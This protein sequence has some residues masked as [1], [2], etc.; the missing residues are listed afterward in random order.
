MKLSEIHTLLSKTRKERNLA[1]RDIASSLNVEQATISLYENGKRGIPLDLLDA[2]L[3][4]LEI[5]IKATPQSL[6]P[7]NRT[8]DIEHDLHTFRELK[9]KRNRLIAEIRAITAEKLL[10]IPKF[11]QTEP[12]SGES[13]FWPY[14]FP[15]TE[16]VGLVETRYDHPEQKHLAV[17]YTNEEVNIY[18]FVPVYEAENEQM[19]TGWSDIKRIYFSEDEFLNLGGEWE[20]DQMEKHK[21]TIL[22]KHANHPDGVEII[23]PEGFPIRALLDMVENYTF[24]SK[25]IK[26]LYLDWQLIKMKH[27]LDGIRKDLTNIMMHNR[28]QNGSVNPDFVL[29]SETDL[30]AIDVPLW[31]GYRNWYWVEEGVSWIEDV[32]EPNEI[33]LTEDKLPPEYHIHRQETGNRVI[34]L[35]GLEQNPAIFASNH[36][37]LNQLYRVSI[38]EEALNEQELRDYRNL[39]HATKTLENI[40]HQEKS[41]IPSEE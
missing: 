20:A 6:V 13:L 9:R 30:E 15:T 2:W 35:S 38:K 39:L 31:A 16:C 40:Q 36:T 5:E 4:L 23:A 29:W 37:G 32:D 7:V 1:Q 34:G 24:F 3:Q 11:Q 14:S 21:I 28:L 18:K 22:R 41:E 33:L 26:E 19:D 17:E 25:A 12:Q 8:E 10:H 27:E